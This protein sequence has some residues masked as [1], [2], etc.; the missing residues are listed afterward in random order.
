MSVFRTAFQILL[1]NLLQAF[2]SLFRNTYS[3]LVQKNPK[4]KCSEFQNQV[5]GSSAPYSEYQGLY[6]EHPVFAEA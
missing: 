1:T 6:L 2:I 5:S 3:K 4:Q